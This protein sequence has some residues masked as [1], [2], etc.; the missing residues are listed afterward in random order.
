MKVEMR[1]NDSGEQTKI[2][3]SIPLNKHG[4]CLEGHDEYMPGVTSQI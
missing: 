2:D 4:S 1:W 3:V